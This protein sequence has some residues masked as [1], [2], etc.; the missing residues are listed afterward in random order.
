ME[1]LR[2]YLAAFSRAGVL[3]KGWAPMFVEER[4]Y[5]LQ[6]GKTADY[7]KAYEEVGLG[8]QRAIL[9]NLIGYFTTEIGILNQVVHMW[10]YESL[11]DRQER[12]KKLYENP[13]WQN[14]VRTI[15]P[16]VMNQENRILVPTSFSPVVGER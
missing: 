2:S 7:L 9:G 13:I 8:V 14:Y 6:P 3:Q 4:T 15:R 10:G 1:A 11:N 12:R 5:T 16:W